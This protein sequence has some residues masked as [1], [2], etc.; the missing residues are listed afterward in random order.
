MNLTATIPVLTAD[1][2]WPALL[3]EERLFSFLPIAVGLLFEWFILWLG[4]FG[5]SWKKAVLIDLVMNAASSA[6]GIVAIP[7]L[8]LAWELAA[9]RTIYSALNVGTF[10]PLGWA[11]TFFLSV[12]C[13]TL[14]EAAVLRWVF[15]IPLGPRRFWTLCGANL[16]STAIAFA[17]LLI[18]PPQ[19]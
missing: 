5:L 9:D 17:S 10:N 16:I 12:G 3:L 18:R 11:V 8:G 19:Y 13:S 6:V 14:I 15:K 2:V 7:A 1:V 4:G